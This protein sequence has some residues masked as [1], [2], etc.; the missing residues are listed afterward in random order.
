MTVSRAI[1]SVLGC[2][3]LFLAACGGSDTTVQDSSTA[4][5]DEIASEIEATDNTDLVQATIAAAVELT[6]QAKINNEAVIEATKTPTPSANQVV[7]ISSTATPSPTPVLTPTATATKSPTPRPTLTP[8]PTRTLLAAV[9]TQTPRPTPTPTPKSRT[10]LNVDWGY[11]VDIPPGWEVDETD[12]SIII[13]TSSSGVFYIFSDD[14]FS[15]ETLQSY[16]ALI[17]TFRSGER[18]P[19]TVQSLLLVEEIQLPT[20]LLGI[21]RVWERP[22]LAADGE[23]VDSR[24][25]NVVV[26][27]GTISYEMLGNAFLSDW[28]TMETRFDDFLASFSVVN[29]GP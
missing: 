2:G 15:S 18:L 28:P 13:L 4:E 17:W 1:W 5:V 10:L 22:I 27:A 20:G 16:D 6:V 12:K 26:R 7:R 11:T 21:R 9:P 29:V 25:M 14:R 24:F 8:R 19:D 23:L 3:L